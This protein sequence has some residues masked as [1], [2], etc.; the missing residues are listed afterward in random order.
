MGYRRAGA[1]LSGEVCAATGLPLGVGL[2]ELGFRGRGMIAHDGA[3]GGGAGAEVGGVEDPVDAA[4]V[5]GVGG[6]GSGAGRGTGVEG[7]E[8]RGCRNSQVAR[9]PVT[10][11]L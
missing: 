9:S 3:D 10:A 5:I 2:S 6:T 8:R 1:G 7:D 11:I 4:G